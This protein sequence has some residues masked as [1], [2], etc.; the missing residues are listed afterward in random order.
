M[1][2]V[3]RSELVD[4]LAASYKPEPKRTAQPSTNGHRNGA[5]GDVLERALRYAAKYPP[6]IQGN[7]GSGT[8]IK[9]AG[10]LVRGFDLGEDQAMQVMRQWSETCEPPWSETE[11]WH[12]VRS[13]TQHPG[14]RGYL[15]NGSRSAT[16]RPSTNGAT[17]RNENRDDEQTEPVRFSRITAAELATSVYQIEYL[18]ERVLVAGQ[19]CIFAGPKKALKT[20]LLVAMAV[21]LAR[22]CDF[23]GRFKITQA[24]RVLVMSGESGIATLQETAKR[25]CKWYGFDLAALGD[26]FILSYDLPQVARFDHLDALAEFLRG[27]EIE[28]VI[29]DPAYLSLPC[30]DVAN[31][32]AV[33]GLL[34]NLSRVCQQEGVTLCVAHHTRKTVANPYEPPELENI[35]F[36]GFQEFARQWI[37]IGRREKYQHGTGSH[38]LWLATGGSAGHS[39]LWAC[40]IEEGS[41]TAVEGRT[42][43]CSIKSAEAAINDAKTRDEETKAAAARDKDAGNRNKALRTLFKAGE[44]LTKNQ[45]KSRCGLSGSAMDRI[46]AA[47]LDAES[48]VGVE[49][50]HGNRR[51]GYP[52]FDVSDAERDRLAKLAVHEQTER[53]E[54]SHDANDRG[55]F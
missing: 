41:N 26:S 44:P 1:L 54:T 3:V 45:W 53:L 16:T 37:L 20:T 7:D 24:R 18:I 48:I 22:G 35:A 38:R 28:V 30:D 13:A 8:A 5:G 23:L 51:S 36:A 14:E 50:K 52:G 10:H 19:P 40:D 2:N 46:I 21:A 55:D 4:A 25:I 12:K 42:F 17:Q 43:D 34:G 6:A 47:L 49:V 15:L 29:I 32:F 39:G 27:D 11:L 9:L 31:L 33:G